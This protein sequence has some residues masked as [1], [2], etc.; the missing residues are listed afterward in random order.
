MSLGQASNGEDSCS[1]MTCLTF[2]ADKHQLKDHFARLGFVRRR[3]AISRN[4][5]ILSRDRGGQ[6]D[7]VTRRVEN[8]IS[9]PR[10]WG[11]CHAL[12]GA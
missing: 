7:F 9:L 11:V 8:S 2:F 3:S 5:E 4:L 1:R 6:A 10:A 12:C